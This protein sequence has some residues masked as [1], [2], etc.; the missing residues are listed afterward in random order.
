MRSV[1]LAATVMLLAASV[2]TVAAQYRDAFRLTDPNQ[3][4]V[5]K[6]ISV[7]RVAASG[8]GLGLAGFAVGGL[9]GAG[10]SGKCTSSDECQAEGAFLGAAV[11]GTLGMAL[12]VHLGNH[13][14]GNY[15]LDALTGAAVWAT[16]IGIAVATGSESA[17]WA[18]FVFIPIVQLVTTVAV[19]RAVGRKRAKALPVALSIVPGIRGTTSVAVSLRF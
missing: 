6:P 10:L 12:G 5:A 14:R 2:P 1:P 8:V 11:G 3:T 9:I 15:A 17:T 7:W 18:A 13:R 19:E 16:G 4:Q